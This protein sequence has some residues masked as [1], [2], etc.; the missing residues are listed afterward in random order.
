MAV[1]SYANHFNV[2]LFFIVLNRVGAIRSV[3]S[4]HPLVLG[5]VCVAKETPRY[6]DA[7]PGQPLRSDRR[8]WEPAQEVALFWSAQV[9][10]KGCV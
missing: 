7:H 6:K 10:L 2:S 1:E 3:F 4:P 5:P 8:L 9:T